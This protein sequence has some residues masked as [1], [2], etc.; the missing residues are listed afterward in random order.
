MFDA[1]LKE[2]GDAKTS[3]LG[4]QSF[5]DYCA[6]EK[7]RNPRTAQ[8]ISIDSLSSL[9]KSLK[10]QNC[11][12]LRLGIPSGEKHTH[13][14]LVQCLSGWEDYFLID[15]QIF[16]ETLPELF[17]P[18]V[19]SKQLF[20][21]TLL[22]AFT[23]TSLVNLALASG[24]MAYALGIEDQQLPLAP[25]TGQSTFSFEFRPRKDMS[26]AW[27]HSKGQV[28]IDSLFTA[29]RDGKETVFVVECKAGANHDSLA[30]HKLLYPVL[31]INTK[32]PPYMPIVPVYIRVITKPDG[33][34]FYF[35]EC[36]VPKKEK[37]LVPILSE[38]QPVS[39]K[40]FVLRIS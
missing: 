5:H 6:R 35:C 21:F 8:Y 26:L 15:K 16:K 36:N 29:K 12:V 22:P 20:P 10:K 24:L 28:E 30:K 25:A 9:H 31:A 38:M 3:F 2:M 13:F 17:I 23:E 37:S 1:A 14:G 39:Q 40:H 27:Y 32:V 19:S 33:Y 18:S 34:H 11:M 4:P 7:I